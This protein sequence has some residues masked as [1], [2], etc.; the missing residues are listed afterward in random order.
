MSDESASWFL[1]DMIGEMGNEALDVHQRDSSALSL[2]RIDSSLGTGRFH[3]E[4]RWWDFF[5]HGIAVA[6]A[7]PYAL[8]WVQWLQS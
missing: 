3:H 6:P 7:I 4:I 1:L 2:A 8:R 5:A